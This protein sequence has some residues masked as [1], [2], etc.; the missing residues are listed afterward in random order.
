MDHFSVF[1][2][3]APHLLMLP[4]KR[5]RRL[6]Q[7]WR[8][9]WKHRRPQ[10]GKG[11]NI[12]DCY[13]EKIYLADRCIAQC[14]GRILAVQR[15]W[16]RSVLGITPGLLLRRQWLCLYGPTVY[17]LRAV[18]MWCALVFFPSV[19][20]LSNNLISQHWMRNT[21]KNHFGLQLISATAQLFDLKAKVDNI[22]GSL[23]CYRNCFHLGATEQCLPSAIFKCFC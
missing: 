14:I 9:S 18:D 19:T 13:T 22:N 20:N 4:N 6:K 21:K 7:N 1:S 23:Q 15:R 5:S 17:A 3:S 2:A 12:E 10:R 11:S 16:E 8:G